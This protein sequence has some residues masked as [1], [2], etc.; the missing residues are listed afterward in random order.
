MTKI[1]FSETRGYLKAI[2]AFVIA[3]VLI[4]PATFAIIGSNSNYYSSSGLSASATQSPNEP[5]QPDD[6][7]D[8][9]RVIFDSSQ[10]PS[11]GSD[12]GSPSSGGGG[13]SDDTGDGNDN[14]DGPHVVQP[15]PIPPDF[16]GCL[17]IIHDD[18]PLELVVVLTGFFMG[19]MHV[20]LNSDGP[21]DPSVY[22]GLHMNFRPNVN[23]DVNTMG[24]KS[25]N[26]FSPDHR[27]FTGTMNYQDGNTYDIDTSYWWSDFGLYEAIFEHNGQTYLISGNNYGHHT[28]GDSEPGFDGKIDPSKLNCD[29]L[30]EA[31][32]IVNGI[33]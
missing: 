14:G 30:S 25:I 32:D 26:L 11:S 6:K 15:T 33:L 24:L 28:S 31:R 19:E 21:Q 18:A 5:S 9:R 27:E 8:N 2:I 13:S 22:I 29:V 16:E 1:K 20:T 4:V 23:A 12:T 7:D 10:P 17:F 3:L